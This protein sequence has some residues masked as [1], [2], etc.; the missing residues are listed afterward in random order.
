[1]REKILVSSNMQYYIDQI[2]NYSDLGF[3][4][5]ILHN[6]NRNQEQFIADFGE[7]LIPIFSNDK[8][9]VI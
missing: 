7:Q 5:I 3:E 1:M 4:R 9:Q 6:V 2:G 8:K